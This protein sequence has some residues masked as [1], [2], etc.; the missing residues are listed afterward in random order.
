MDPPRDL[1]EAL[2]TDDPLED[3]DALVAAGREQL[4]RLALA[5]QDR[6]W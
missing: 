4:V 2:E 6:T 3:R 1:L 5:Q